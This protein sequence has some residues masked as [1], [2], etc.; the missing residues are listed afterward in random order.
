MAKGNKYTCAVCG[1][2]YDYC[3]SC[4]IRTP[5][6]DKTMFCSEKHADIFATLSKHGCKL[7]TADETLKALEKYNLNAE[8]LTP[9]IRRHI[10]TVKSE[11]APAQNE[12]R[13][14]QPTTV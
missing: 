4:E 2:Q 7:A 1:K 5:N 8:S 12:R 3:P 13:F 9:E 10:T 14:I 6:Y 11:A